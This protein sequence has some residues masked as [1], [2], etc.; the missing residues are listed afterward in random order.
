MHHALGPAQ[1]KQ[2]V[3]LWLGWL[4]EPRVRQCT[5]T[6]ATNKRAALEVNFTSCSRTCGSC[7]RFE[8]SASRLHGRH[9]SAAANSFRTWQKFGN[10]LEKTED[11]G[12]M[13]FPSYSANEKDGS[14]VHQ[15]KKK[16]RFLNCISE[17]VDAIVLSFRNLDSDYYLLV[18][19]GSWFQF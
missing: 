16:G 10:T 1:I 7:T 6:L 3:V 13:P 19:L 14:S 12:V 18:L 4:K 8:P 5:A 2:F 11:K 9:G 15:E 17:I